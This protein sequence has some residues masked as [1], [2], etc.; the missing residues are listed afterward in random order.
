VPAI[1][2][3]L[4]TIYT[5][6]SIKVGKVNNMQNT[7]AFDDTMSQLMLLRVDIHECFTVA[8][9]RCLLNRSALQHIT[10]HFNE[11]SR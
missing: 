2:R 4:L 10:E 3:V 9:T 1:E 8:S 7:V 6:S 11:T 5:R